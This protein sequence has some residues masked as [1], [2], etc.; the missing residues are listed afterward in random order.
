MRPLPR[1][2][3]S[4]IQ[5]AHSTRQRVVVPWL[6]PRRLRQ[7]R[8]PWRGW[9]SAPTSPPPWLAPCTPSPARERARGSE[10]GRG[11]AIGSLAVPHHHPRKMRAAHGG[12]GWPPS[13]PQPAGA[14]NVCSMVS[15]RQYVGAPSAPVQATCPRCAEGCSGGRSSGSSS[16]SSSSR[17]H[18]HNSSR[19]HR[20]ARH[21]NQ[22]EGPIAPQGEVQVIEKRRSGPR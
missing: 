2:P 21:H 17:H 6:Q 1:G 9:P 15:A 19:H 4:S 8:A 7:Q 11:V 22:G 10:S 5:S 20:H 14:C 3:S 16:R 18:A 13:P 12:A